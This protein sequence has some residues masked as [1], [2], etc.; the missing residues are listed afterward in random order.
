MGDAAVV[1][2][3]IKAVT[4]AGREF[5]VAA[6]SDASLDTGGIE[7]AVEVTGSGNSIITQSRVAWSIQNISL[8]VSED[9]GDLGFLAGIFNAAV[10]AVGLGGLAID[11]PPSGP[12]R[13]YLNQ[14]VSRGKFV[15]ISITLVDD[16]TYA[17]RGTI[18]GR[19]PVSTKTGTASLS[20]EGDG[21]MVKQ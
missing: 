9:R 14:V 12:D 7:N 1:A 16:T 2:G 21:E 10:D 3:S 4:I 18:V 5:P 8:V 19:I 13:D 11:A 20:F 15:T 6:D 17:G